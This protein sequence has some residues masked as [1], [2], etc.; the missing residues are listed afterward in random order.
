M[1]T[2]VLHIITQMEA[3]GAQGAAV[4]NSRAMRAA[5][6]DSTVVFLYVKRP[7]YAD[8][9]NVLAL[10][11]RKP[12]GIADACKIL[13][14][15][16]RYLRRNRDASIISYTHYANV[17]SG[18]VGRLVGVRRIVSSHRNP[19]NTYPRWCR[20]LDYLLGTSGGYD[21]G[22]AVSET[23]YDSFRDYPA[24]YLK[25]LTVIRN[26]IE[27]ER[28]P[29]GMGAPT[30]ADRDNTGLITFIT[31]GRLHHQK[32]QHVIIR[33]MRKLPG[34][35]LIIA[36]EGEL[37]SEL[38]DLIK[39]EA[40]EDRVTLLGEIKPQDV[41]HFLMQGDV[42]LFPSKYEAFGFSV[43]EAMAAGCPIICS[44]IPAMREVVAEA[45]ILVPP[46]EVDA[47]V[48]AMRQ[49]MEE[50]SVIA[51]MRDRSIA[52]ASLFSL[53]QMVEG[54]MRAAQVGPSRGMVGLD[55]TK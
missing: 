50:P 45:G 53:K 38:E 6:L 14:R 20:K 35:R 15:L 31:T 27:L 37:R 32:N 39:R 36:G 4:R 10:L 40:I 16:F 48:A 55:K 7:V 44:D 11:E 41:R 8:E 2:K 19:V 52:R 30:S 24:R 13:F 9:P 12:R 17:I 29:A 33:A 46:H 3:A 1:T 21:A 22:I 26:G 42:F 49:I 18:V 51:Q 47:W 28:G 25:R 54:Y 43:V 34:A 5:G 23:V